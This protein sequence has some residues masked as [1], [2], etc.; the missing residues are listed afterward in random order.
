MSLKTA[1]LLTFAA[2][3]PLAAAVPTSSVLESRDMPR[4]RFGSVPYGTRLGLGVSPCTTPG[5]IALTFDDGPSHLTKTIVDTLQTEGVKATFFIVG[6]NGD[7]AGLTR[8][9][10]HDLVKFMHKEGHHLA[11]HTFTHPDLATLSRAQVTE[12]L[13]KNEAVF[14]DVLGFVPTYFRPPYTSC[15]EQCY[16][17]LNELGYHVVDYNLD[18]LDWDVKSDSKAIFTK[19]MSSAD[20]K[21]NSYISLS[22]DVQEFTANGFVKSMIDQA[23]AKGLQF[24]TVGECLGDP[25]ANWYRDPVTGEPIGSVKPPVSSSS[26]S[27]SSSSTSSVEPPRGSPTTTTTGG[28]GSGTGTTTLPPVTT[29]TTTST[30][31]PHYGNNTIVTATHTSYT[32]YCPPVNPPSGFVPLPPAPTGTTKHQIP[33]PKTIILPPPTGTG[34][35]VKPPTDTGLPKPPPVTAGAGRIAVANIAAASLFAAAAW[36]AL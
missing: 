32:T 16:S 15:D 8:P 22:H 6:K 29:P 20:P 30:K 25:A 31:P 23:R 13:V 18:T 26:S 35:I 9:E 12:E 24:V 1:S 3:A 5:K 7:F 28:S 4:P 34:A 27:T 10:Y 21:A 19:A 11:S 33:G 17:V 36:L 14:A 2:L